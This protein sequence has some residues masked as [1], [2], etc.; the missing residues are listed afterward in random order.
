[1]YRYGKIETLTVSNLDGAPPENVNGNA[2]S[3]VLQLQKTHV[4]TRRAEA[5]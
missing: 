5:E 2:G 4:W 1:M 3:F